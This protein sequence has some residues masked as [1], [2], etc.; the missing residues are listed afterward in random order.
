[1]AEKKQKRK[2]SKKGLWFIVVALLAVG[3]FIGWQVLDAQQETSRVLANLEMEPYRRDN[4][5]AFI[6][7]TGSVQ[8]SQ[9]AALTWSANGTVG[10]VHVSLGDTVEKDRVLMSLDPDSLSMDIMQAEIDL[11]NAQRS[12]DQLY[13]NWEAD[14]ANARL[15]LLDAEENLEDRENRRWVMDYRRCSDDRIEELEEALED[16]QDL[17]DF[18]D[19]A[20]NRRRVNTAQAN[21]DY[22]RANFSD[23]EIAEAELQIE[24]AV[25]QV[26]RLQTEVNIL[27]DGP[28][29]DEVTILETRIAI[30]Q[31]RLDSPMIKAPFAGVVTS[32]PVQPGDVVQMGTK[33]VQLDNLADLRLNV[34][35]SE[36]DIP[37]VMVGQPVQLVFDAFFETIFNGEVK[38]ISLVGTTV[39]GV[40]EYTVTVRMLD[41]DDR[42]RPGMTAAVTI[43]VDEK[44]DVFVVPN[45]AIVNQN[46]QEQ[47][48]VRRN[49]E[50]VSV[51]VVLGSFSDFY[52]EV[53]E[54]DINEG[55]MIVLNPPAEITG[56][57][58]FGGPPGGG[59][60][61]G[62]FGN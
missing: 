56:A 60:F 9:S 4:L 57:A 13:E 8:P 2:K 34:Q 14:L 20:E 59:G 44:E 52:S 16:A 61:G 40:V 15:N 31:S 62:P 18:R 1:M 32:L 46:G 35:I 6:F 12:L 29:A 54:A 58:P 36:I 21:L 5:S 47:V 38:E 51:P 50:F 41:A 27:S 42:I 23:R 37:Q 55:E 25:T 24:L 19:T 39:Q 26:N 53:L 33:A 17:L 48:F 28:D 30:A 45:D 49:G 43:V 3:L 11:I 10:E 7:G 22:C